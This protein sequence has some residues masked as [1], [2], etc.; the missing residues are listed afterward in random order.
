MTFL[1][2][3]LLLGLGLVAVPIM[4]HLLLR[5]RPK[6][7]VFPAL[8]L[9][10]QR[11]QQ[12]VRR[13]RLRQLWLLLLRMAVIGAIVVAL[14]RPSLPPANYA[15]TTFETGTLA[16][17]IALGLAAYFAIMI[18]WERQPW[19]RH[20]LL[21]RR[22]ML[23]GGLG[24]GTLLLALLFFA[25][26]YSRRISA[27]IT[28]PAPQAFENIP[29]AAVFLCDTSASMSYQFEGASRLEAARR[30]V[31][32]HLQELPQ[33]S[34]AA[35]MDLANDTPA[36]FTPDLTAVQNRLES[37]TVQS[38]APALNERLRAALR[39]HDDDRRRTL[40]EQGS[41]AEDR[42]QDRFIREVYL[43]TDLAKSSW[44]DDSSH[45]LRDELL[46]AP[47][48]GVYLIDVG[49][50]QP[51]NSGVVDVKLSR[52]AASPGSQ[53]QVTATIA[54]VGAL[55]P[56][57]TVE[58]WVQGEDGKPAKRDQHSVSLPATGGAEATF[59]L[60]V[61]QGRYLQ[62][63]VRLV[64]SDPLSFDNIG[65]LTVR[66]LPPLE[67]LVVAE[68]AEQ[69]DFWLE[70]LD[71]LNKT[72]TGYRPTFKLAS[73][74]SD[75]DLSKFEM[76]CLINVASPSAELW[77]KLGQ[78]V[79]NGGGVAVF[80]GDRSAV[81]SG[82][83]RGGIDPITYNS[84][85]AQAWLPAQLKAALAF[86]PARQLDFRDSS[87]PFTQRLE[88]FGVLSELGD[89]DFHRYWK[90]S[91]HETALV[92]ARWNDDGAQP[93]LMLRPVGR[94]RAMLFASSV[95]SIAWNELPRN[96]T[97]LVLADQMLQMLSR[98]AASAHTLRVGDPVALPLSQPAKSSAGLLRLP[99]FTQRPVEL[100][101]DTRDVQLPATTQ[102]GHYQVVSQDGPPTSW[103]AAFSAN[104][105]PGESDLTRLTTD[106]LDDLLGAKRYGLARDPDQLSRSVHAGRLGQ[107]VYGL[108]MAALLVA[109][110]WEQTTATWF[111]KAD[112]K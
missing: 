66:V 109:F 42:R 82:A 39:F 6:R 16:A 68:R 74:L 70:A 83:N 22:T 51:V 86:S 41:V 28:A 48:L 107:E 87:H 98:Q 5:A 17:V 1:H 24:A 88:R 26:P 53:V 108:L 45:T 100:D 11:K 23:R 32:E 44:R 31:S 78:Y 47:W 13:L 104:P 21:T 2:P 92:L 81:I 91:P 72:G 73:A 36:V 75:V 50:E 40:S 111:Y 64:T 69:A 110:A 102:P 106:N 90:V 94:G 93:A 84:N 89:I 55:K 67:V 38:L 19:P 10:Q 34:K 46:A 35:V 96:W 3:V 95:D 63:E 29:V 77:E 56:E 8:R 62:G 85:A 20:V 37:L 9:L 43:L 33:G 49:I 65:F 103:L 54:T 15:P 27:E 76:V 25:W 61:L 7:L 97:F 59:A 57:Q 105:L 99:D 71:A 80:L 18:W 101:P 52:P 4:L 112:E 60:D 14:S 58:L 30:I 79:E 12:N